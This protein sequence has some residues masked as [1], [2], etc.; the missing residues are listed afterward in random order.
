MTKYDRKM[1]RRQREKEREKRE[2]KIGRIITVVFVVAVVALAASFP[3]RRYAAANGT[4]VTVGG[5]SVTRTEFDYYYNVVSQNYI[6]QYGSYLSYFGL[7][8]TKDFSTQMYSDT[9]T[10]KDYFEQMAVDSI[11]EAKALQ[12]AA[13]TAGFTYDASRGVEDF[14]ETLKKSASNAKSSTQEYLR[15]LYGN[16]ATMGSVCSFMEKSLRGNAYY[17]K[18]QKDRAASDEEIRAYYEANKANYDSVDYYQTII[19]AEISSEEPTEEE[20]AKAMEDARAEADATDPTAGELQENKKQ[21][22]AAYQIRDWL[23]DEARKEGDSTVIEDTYGQQYY[24]V[25]F[26]KRYL[27]DTPTVDLRVIITQNNDG[28]VILDEWKAGAATEE[29]FEELYEKYSDMAAYTTDGSLME[30]VTQT[31]L[32]DVLEEWVFAEGRAAG[33]TAAIVSAS[34]YHYVLYYVGEGDPEWQGSI[35]GT[36]SNEAMT[37]Y[38]EEISAG[39]T[40]EDKKGRLKYLKVQEQENAEDGQ[41]DAGGS[42]AE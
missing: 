27:D 20:T 8:T 16:Y 2:K 35:A 13:D 14:K 38:M 26:V 37:A 24:V 39:I 5:E 42:E 21:S 6:N 34:G 32:E 9:L 1:Q 23:F 22:A 40:V 28:Q 7:D 19:T 30:G 3:I 36:L 18:V 29:S 25:S 4:Y 15:Q 10:W 33:D 11:T 31:D 17:S 12:R 41:E